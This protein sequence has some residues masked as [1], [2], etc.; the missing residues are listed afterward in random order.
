MSIPAA[1]ISANGK[2]PA[3]SREARA[4]TRKGVILALACVAQFMVVLDVSI[5]NVALPSIQHDLHFSPAGLQWVVNAYALTFAGFLMLG[6]RAADL[7]GRRKI[8]ILGIGLFTL[9]SLIGGISQSADWLTAARAAQGLGGAVLSPAT[10]TLLITTFPEGKARAKALGTW[11][12]VAG[13]GAAAGALL[14][15]LLTQYLSWRYV[16]FINVPI[17]IVVIVC[18]FVFLSEGRRNLLSRSLDLPGAITITG[19]MAL[20]IYGIVQT[21]SHGWTSGRTIGLLAGAVAVLIAFVVIEARFAEAPLVPLSIFRIRSVSSANAVMLILG[22]GFLVSFYFISLFMQNVLGYDAIK[23]GLLF[24]PAVFGIAIGAQFAA[25]VVS[26]V[27]ARPLLVVGMVITSGGFFWF[28]QITVSSTF[29]ANL[30]GP[31]VLMTL[32]IG[33]CFT[34]IATAGTAGVPREQSGLASALI[35]TSRQVGGSI[36]LAAIATVAVDRT[37][38]LLA[39]SSHSH[40]AT[41]I[42]LTSGYSR[43][44][45]VAAGTSLIAAIVALSV[46]G[47]KRT[48]NLV[49]AKAVERHNA[50]HDAQLG[51]LALALT[52]RIIESAD[53]QHPNLINAAAALAPDHPG[54]VHERAGHAA[55]HVLRPM[56]RQ[57]LD[58]AAAER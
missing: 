33:L 19:G 57:L 41:N 25:R 58:Q 52:S 14:G 37:N 55:R 39:G 12:A 42:A 5:V 35:N 3:A 28:S 38:A 20:L 1:A 31:S 21:S 54:S 36:G 27:G 10:L 16:L 7:Y 22:I 43:A 26:R 51:A 17:G 48:A 11:S 44:F 32:G 30:L 34:P 40:A 56:A 23:T 24:L 8:F 6:G 18:A 45:L 2:H 47:V 29:V 13:A 9:A 53:G 46:P 15:G 4:H 50:K 49:A